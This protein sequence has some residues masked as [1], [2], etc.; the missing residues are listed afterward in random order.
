MQIASLFGGHMAFLKRCSTRS[1]TP[2]HIALTA[3]DKQLGLAHTALLS[4]PATLGA[5]NVCVKYDNQALD[6]PFQGAD[7]ALL[8]LIR[9]QADGLLRA[10]NVSDSLEAA[11]RAAIAQR[12]FVHVSCDDI[13]SDLGIPPHI[14]TAPEPARYAFPSG[15]GGRMNGRGPASSDP[16]QHAAA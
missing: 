9:A 5:R 1:V 10:Q 6:Q 8:A 12:G 2:R 3:P 11:V 13:A 14:A 16:W 15:S 7:S 4:C